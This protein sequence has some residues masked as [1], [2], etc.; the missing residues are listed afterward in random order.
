MPLTP[1]WYQHLSRSLTNTRLPL[2]QGQQ[3]LTGRIQVSAPWVE[4]PS[5]ALA[6][7]ETWA[8]IPGEVNEIAANFWVPSPIGIG[9]A[10]IALLV[11]VGYACKYW[12]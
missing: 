4:L 11:L 3:F 8:L 6:S 2:L 12:I 7:S 1:W 10:A 5:G 9:A